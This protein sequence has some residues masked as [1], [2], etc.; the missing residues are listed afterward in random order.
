[1]SAKHSNEIMLL[2]MPVRCWFET[3]KSIESI[4]EKLGDDDAD[5]IILKLLRSKLK[6]AM[7]NFDRKER[8]KKFFNKKK[9]NK[10]KG[11][12]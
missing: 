12:K 2:D 5:V 8:R 1:M 3:E 9:Q 11:L 10:T 7:F 4:S 6:T